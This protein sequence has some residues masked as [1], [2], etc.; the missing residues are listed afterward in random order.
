LIG[1]SNELAPRPQHSLLVWGYG[2]DT[3]SQPD[4]SDYQTQYHDY[5]AQ[6]AASLAP[7]EIGEASA[8][9]LNYIF[10]VYLFWS[11]VPGGP[12]RSLTAIPSRWWTVR[13]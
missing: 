7:A 1:S 8:N 6:T 4:Y 5:Q 3:R 2:V 12:R 11:V 9:A 10:K 13:H